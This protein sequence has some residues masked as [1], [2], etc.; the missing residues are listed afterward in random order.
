MQR[1]DGVQGT[2][3]PI[4]EKSTGEK[5]IKNFIRCVFLQLTT[6]TSRNI[7]M[8]WQSCPKMYMMT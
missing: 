2:S 8:I 5:A 4:G 1:G 7:W 6:L 3:M